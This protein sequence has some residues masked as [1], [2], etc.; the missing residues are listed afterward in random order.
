MYVIHSLSSEVLFK[1][2][3]HI[4]IFFRYIAVTR[5]TIEIVFYKE[6]TILGTFKFNKPY[7]ETI[8]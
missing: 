7:Y 5:E 4:N 8:S 3:L 1:S 6:L 2:Q